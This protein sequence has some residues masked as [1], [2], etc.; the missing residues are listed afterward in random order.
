MEHPLSPEY[1]QEFEHQ[2]LRTLY[3]PSPISALASRIEQ[4]TGYA[5]YFTNAY[6]EFYASSPG[7][8]QEDVV[9]LADLLHIAQ[10][11]SKNYSDYLEQK[12]EFSSLIGESPALVHIPKRHCTYLFASAYNESSYSGIVVIPEKRRPLAELPR[13]Y[14]DVILSVFTLAQTLYTAAQNQKPEQ[15]GW[16]S[17]FRQLITGEINNRHQLLAQLQDNS[18]LVHIKTYVIFVFSVRSR[19]IQETE[20]AANLNGYLKNL[21]MFHTWFEHDGHMVMILSD[22]IFQKNTKALIDSLDFQELVKT[23]DLYV[24]YSNTFS[25]LLDAGLAYENALT[26][27][28]F[29]RRWDTSLHISGYEECKLFDL[30]QHVSGTR[31]SLKQYISQSVLLIQDYDSAHDSNYFQTLELLFENRMNLTAAAGKLF[32]HKSTLFYR[33]QQMEKLFQ[34]DWDDPVMVLHLQLSLYMLKYMISQ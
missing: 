34:I 1:L 4:L 26:A 7:I 10:V 29:S 30:L 3:V 19:A 20:T 6:W 16:N 2:L 11:R 9:K 15:K 23:L 33:M 32:I 17:I 8:L 22:D 18:L 5:I 31:D 21:Q 28:K 13:A 24:G 25:H 14:I 27:A 12:A